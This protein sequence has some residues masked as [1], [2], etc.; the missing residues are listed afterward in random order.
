MD[1]PIIFSTDMVKAI[2]EGRKTQTRRLVK[3]QPQRF[4]EVNEDPVYLYDVEWNIGIINPPYQP[5]DRLY[6]RET[7]AKDDNGDYVYRTNYGK[8][9]D[10]SFP[11]SMFKWRPSI[12]MPREASRIR[13]LVK[14]VRVERVQDIMPDDVLLEGLVDV[15]TEVN[16]LDRFAES[17]DSISAKRGFGW[18]TNPYVW[19]IE[20]E[21]I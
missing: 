1:K 2:L 7:W 13:L 20:F 3:P 16:A 19:V 17:W 9:E 5:G 14:S 6:V 21:V 15:G 18:V 4:F 12:H 10:D 11:P 8:T